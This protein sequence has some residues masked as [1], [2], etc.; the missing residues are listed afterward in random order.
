[1]DVEETFV[2]YDA[3]NLKRTKKKKIRKSATSDQ[4]LPL[5][6]SDWTPCDQTS[7][8]NSQ[9]GDRIEFTASATPPALSENSQLEYRAEFTALATPLASSKSSQSECR[10]Q[11]TA[12][13]TSSENSQLED[14]AECAILAT[15]PEVSGYKLSYCTEL[16]RKPPSVRVRSVGQLFIRG[17]NIVLIAKSQSHNT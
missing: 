17:D 10:T 14:K 13:A 15:P 4:T 1:M 6:C 2:P 5:H 7:S 8:E 9:S 16:Y 11:T 12:L 3:R